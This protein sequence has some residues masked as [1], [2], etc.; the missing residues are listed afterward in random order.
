MSTG[1][2]SLPRKLALAL[3]LPLLVCARPAAAGER[4]GD[5][6]DVVLR[7]LYPK[8]RTVEVGAGAGWL[9]NPTFVETSLATLRFRYHWSEAWGLGLDIGAA[10]TRDR[11]ERRCV[12]T[13]YN[14]PL[15]EAGASC[16]ADDGGASLEESEHV[17]LGPAYVPIRELRGLVALYGDYT[18]GYG[19]Q[20]LLL[21][22]TSHFDLRVRAG[23]GDVVSDFYE[24]RR[25]VRGHPERPSR[26]DPD[27]D[28]GAA[29]AGVEPGEA[30]GDGLLYGDEGRPAPRRETTPALYLGLAEELHVARRFFV[31][32]ELA[33]YAMTSA[34][35]GF[36][37]FLVAELGLGLRL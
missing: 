20:I 23:A 7:R 4:A 31:S 1:I 18:L 27:G 17:N 30:D 28:G 9:L 24:E 35:R 2:R 21:G 19:K 15:H 11:N 26:G 12:E 10:R 22:A 33:A 29:K 25:T 3:A 14:D 6:D 8:T 5:S 34:E 32:A 36:E 16:S 13:F 37:P